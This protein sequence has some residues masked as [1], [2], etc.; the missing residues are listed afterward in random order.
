MCVGGKVLKIHANLP[1]S[2]A[3][4]VYKA[5]K[6]KAPNDLW[7]TYSNWAGGYMVGGKYVSPTGPGRQQDSDTGFHAYATLEEAES[8]HNFCVHLPCLFY[9]KV[10]VQ[11]E[12][13]RAQ[14]MLIFDKS[15]LKSSKVVRLA[16]KKQQAE[17]VKAAAVEKAKRKVQEKLAKAALT[18]YNAFRK[19]LNKAVI[20]ADNLSDEDGDEMFKVPAA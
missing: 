11:E 5:F 20:D 8:H 13:L 3:L 10:V 17:A 6:G 1:L 14:R 16:L 12:G 15:A 9:G 7:P 4:L 19:S 2:R 18:A